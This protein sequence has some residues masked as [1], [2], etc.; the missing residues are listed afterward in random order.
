MFEFGRE[1]ARVDSEYHTMEEAMEKLRHELVVA[2]FWGKILC[3][4][5]GTTSPDFINIFKTFKAEDETT[6]VD[7]SVLFNYD[8]W[9]KHDNNKVIARVNEIEMMNG[10]KCPFVMSKDFYMYFVLECDNE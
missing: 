5:L 10:S 3:V 7:A 2:M 8:E 6:D 9:Y 1:V 4:N